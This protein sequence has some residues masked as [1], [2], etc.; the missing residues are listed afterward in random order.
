MHAPV[1]VEEGAELSAAQDEPAVASTGFDV[2]SDTAGDVVAAEDE[3]A[4]EA[5]VLEDV[6]SGEDEAAEG[7]DSLATASVAEPV[8]ALAGEDTADT[9]PR[10][11]A[12]E[13][14]DANEGMSQTVVGLTADGRA[15]NDPRVSPA[16]VQSVRIETARMS[17]FTESPAPAVAAPDR[18][19]PRASNDPRGPRDEARSVDA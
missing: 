16:P 10:A 14:D 2:R 12:G 3:V 17:L 19:V 7:V 6:V 15:V 9:T 8:A 18:N 5:Q 11:G 1:P 13:P 4:V